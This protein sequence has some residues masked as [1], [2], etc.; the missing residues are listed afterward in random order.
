MSGRYYIWYLISLF[1]TVLDEL[2][3]MGESKYRTKVDF[4]GAWRSHLLHDDGE[5]RDRIYYKVLY[6]ADYPPDRINYPDGSRS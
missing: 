3:A 6:R 1:E 2:E 4:G 5:A